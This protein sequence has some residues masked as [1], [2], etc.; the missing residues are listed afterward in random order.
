MAEANIDERT[1]ILKDEAG[2]EVTYKVADMSE[3]AKV[4][5]AKLE[6]VGKDSQSVRANAEFKLEQNDILQKHYVEAIKPLL[7]SEE[8]KTEEVEDAKS[9]KKAN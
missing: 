1:L 6:I 3:E 2:E 5:Y 7:S 9:K 8:E 4:I